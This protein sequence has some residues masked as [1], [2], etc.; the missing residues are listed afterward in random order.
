MSST[1]TKY[2]GIKEQDV[3]L[4]KLVKRLVRRGSSPTKYFVK[5][6][7]GRLE[8]GPSSKKHPSGKLTWRTIT[9]LA[10]AKEQ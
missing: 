10:K 1:A 9:A 8:R 2:K 7:D 3:S 4:D 6:T 5:G